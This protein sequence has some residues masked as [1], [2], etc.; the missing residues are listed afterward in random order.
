VSQPFK[1][2][3]GSLKLTEQFNS[4]LLRGEWRHCKRKA[5]RADIQANPMV[6]N[7]SYP[8]LSP[9]LFKVTTIAE[10]GCRYL[11]RDTDVH[12]LKDHVLHSILH[13]GP[14]QIPLDTRL[15][16]TRPGWAAIEFIDPPGEA[17]D[18]ISEIFRLELKAASLT[19][20]IS[21]STVM[22][23]PTHT[24]IYSDGDSNALELQMKND[25]LESFVGTLTILDL[26]FSWNRLRPNML[27][28]RGISDEKTQG[29]GYKGQ[30][31]SF[32]RNLQDLH[33]AV[34]STI[35]RIGG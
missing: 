2:D 21:F 26:K 14:R 6:V 8:Q 32:I 30:L 15:V 35:E 22:S 1:D 5:V 12:K 11:T 4:F 33:P 17:R 18:L 13:L 28:I 9:Q 19:P 27:S 23:G 25:R 29:P 31:L 16:G 3:E 34:L 7:L 10:L 24:M 20:F